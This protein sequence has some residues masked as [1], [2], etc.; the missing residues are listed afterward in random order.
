MSINAEEFLSGCL[1]LRGPAKSLDLAILMHEVR[2]MARRLHAHAHHVET[3][4]ETLWF[5]NS[6]AVAQNLTALRAAG[7]AQLLNCDDGDVMAPP[8]TIGALFM[9]QKT[10]DPDREVQKNAHTLK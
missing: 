7:D 1:R 6:Q 3:Q 9:T 8:D 2:R 10:E 5:Q 4:L